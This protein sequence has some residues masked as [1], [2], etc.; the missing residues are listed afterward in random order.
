MDECADILA[1]GMGYAD[2]S[3][4]QEQAKSGKTLDRPLPDQERCL[5]EGMAWRI[6]LAG[7]ALFGD[8]LDAL[9]M[10]WPACRMSVRASYD[11]YGHLIAPGKNVFNIAGWSNRFAWSFDNVPPP[12]LKAVLRADGQ[13]FLR[14]R[15]E[16]LQDLVQAFWTEATDLS[17]K[18]LQ[19]EIVRSSW[20]S[21]DDAFRR[22]PTR[23]APPGLW[24]ISYY[25]SLGELVGHGFFFPET[26]AYLKQIY[27]PDGEK[28]LDALKAL[29][30]REAPP[31]GLPSLP[32]VI[33]ADEDFAS[34][35]QTWPVSQEP[36]PAELAD[37]EIAGRQPLQVVDRVLACGVDF[38]L[39]SEQYTRRP[40]TFSP[41]EFEGLLGLHLPQEEETSS[42]FDWLLPVVP[43][44]LDESTLWTIRRVL[45]G[46]TVL[47]E[48][49]SAWLAKHRNQAR[50]SELLSTMARFARPIIAE[51]AEHARQG[52][53]GMVAA[54]DAPEGGK[55]VAALY[56]ELRGLSLDRL[57]DYALDYYDKN[58][59][60]HDG[61]PKQREPEF[62]AYACL[63]NLGLD[64]IWAF[65]RGR[66]WL[67]LFCLVRS[68]LSKVDVIDEPCVEAIGAQARTL[69]TKTAQLLVMLEELDQ[70]L[71]T[72]RLRPY[73]RGN[74]DWIEVAATMSNHDR[75]PGL[76]L[77]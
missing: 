38:S 52:A 13:L 66:E 71:G 58:G 46:L 60:R 15:F 31:A 6:Y 7:A 67:G 75:V 45:D 62:M 12:H 1:A 9:D 27:P 77:T 64:P 36:M 23:A 55:R 14:E 70:G 54:F 20:L 30:R 44:A 51:A 10:L 22:Y 50:L 42:D 37:V 59:I 41:E 76:S 47:S 39:G 48:A 4:L 32:P 74:T 2:A 16:Y 21:L 63:R 73:P 72:T 8:A 40:N 35:W 5:V 43:Y 26:Q 56:P 11:A 17:L 53:H 61:H 65:R 34:P 3:A 24:P 57:G 68:E 29:W 18:E 69:V 25:D 28:L 19:D 49:E 33:F